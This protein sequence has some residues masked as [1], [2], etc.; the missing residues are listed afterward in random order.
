MMEKMYKKAQEE[1][2]ISSFVLIPVYD[3]KMEN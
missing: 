1:W 2:Q 3:K